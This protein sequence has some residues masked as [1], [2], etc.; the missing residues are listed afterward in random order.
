M[1]SMEQEEKRSLDIY[2]LD[3][4]IYQLVPLSVYIN[5]RGME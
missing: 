2:I 5:G 4:I 1:I 3:G